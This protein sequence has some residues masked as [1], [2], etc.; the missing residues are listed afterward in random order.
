LRRKAIFLLYRTLEILASPA[1][2]LYLLARVLR[3]HR[4]FPTLRER[5]GELSAL[6]QKTAPEAIWLHAVSVG[7]VLASVPLIEELRR[8]TPATPLFVSTSTL[9]GRE[10]ATQKLAPLV[11]GVFYAPFDYVWIVRRVLRCIRP[12]VVVILETEIWPNLFREAK[13][14]GC[15]LVMVNGRISDRALPRYRALAPVFAPVLSL[16]DRILVQSDEMRGRFMASGAPNRIIEVAGNLKYD[17]SLTPLAPDSPVWAFVNSGQGSRLWIAASTSTDG[18]LEEEDDVIAAQR[19]LPGWRLIVAPRKP[20]RFDLV[21]KKLEASCLRFTRRTTLNDPGADVLLLDSIGELAGT[22]EHADAVFMGGT[23]SEMGGHNILEPA[24]AGKPVVAGPH[25]ENFREIEMHFEAH[26]AVIRIAS[27][28]ELAQAIARA[29]DDPDLGRRGFAAAGM[30]GGASKRAADA[31]MVLYNGCYPSDRVPQPRWFFLWWFS[32]FWRAGSARDRRRKRGR[33]RKLPVPVV[34]V[35]NITAGG[36]GKTPVTLELLRDLSAFR[37]GLL[38]RGH[39]RSTKD[40]VLLAHAG[41]LPPIERTGDEAQ[42]YIRTSH[43][44]MG[45]GADRYETGSRLLKSADVGAILLDDGFQHLQLHRD[46][47]LVLIDA[48]MPFGGGHLLPLGRLREP[49]EGLARADAFLITR[50]RAAAN[51]PAIVSTLRRYNPDAPIYFAWLENRH[52]TNLRGETFDLPALSGVKSIAFCGL[53]NPGSF[54]RSLADVGV[55]PIEKH[56]YGDHHRYTP[57]ELRR[58]ARHAREAGAEAL[59]TTAKDSV[60]LCAEFEAVADP[61]K[62]YW[63]EIGIGIDRREDLLARIARKIQAGAGTRGSVPVS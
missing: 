30:K 58:L 44:P 42:L 33:V 41:E 12:S 35:G 52:W 34:S 38:T 51:L 56:S 11:A 1:I 15:G 49:L 26:R 47:D 19:A 21:A 61:L 62:V 16:C 2:I 29:A 48:M 23:L 5:L 36:T 39:G 53:G 43:V 27:G 8:R 17:F 63:L 46:F 6:W 18:R 28:G 4:Y 25:L 40:I 13:R 24:M 7:E 45:I 57:A 3:D 22:F 31:V 14:I 54:W 32:Q 59:L 37:P 55:S 10:L 50:S 60:N 20:H 9:A